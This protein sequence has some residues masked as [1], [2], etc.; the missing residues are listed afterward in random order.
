MD[1][2]IIEDNQEK[3]NTER[4]HRRHTS[5]VKGLAQAIWQRQTREIIQQKKKPTIHEDKKDKQMFP[6]LGLP[7]FPAASC[8]LLLGR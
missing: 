3:N 4:K 6:A 8:R 2:T 7:P 1:V 5:D